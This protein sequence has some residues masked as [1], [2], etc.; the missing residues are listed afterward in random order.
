MKIYVLDRD[1]NPELS[2]GPLEIDLML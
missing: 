2:Q 1:M